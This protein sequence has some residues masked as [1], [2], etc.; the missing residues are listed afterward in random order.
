LGY[1]LRHLLRRNSRAGS[2]RN[3]QAHYDLGN[4]FYR[5]WLDP[6]MTYSSACF[7]DAPASDLAQAQQTKYRRMLELSGAK[8]GDS[9][10]E[11]G[12][13]WGGFA[14]YA[15]GQGMRVHGVTLSH[16]QLAYARRRI[17]QAG[18][19]G[20]A[21]IEL[22]DY[23]DLRGQYD[24]IVSIEMLEAVG[25]AY[26]AGYFRQLDALLKP[27]GRAAVQSIVIEEASFSHYRRGTDFIQQYIFP[28]GMLPSR[29]RIAAQAQAQA[30][31]VERIETFAADYAETLRRW[32]RRFEANLE[33]VHRLGFDTEFI[34]L[35]RFYLAYCEAGFDEGRIDLLQVGLKKGAAQ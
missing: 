20:L 4:D 9:I 32:S 25:E 17:A 11:I 1:R 35:W 15:A 19:A 16:Q 27:G 3:I 22:R 6:G 33:A 7:E 29:E 23:R 8:P 31:Q 24:A 26:W 13:G 30:L 10:L 34:R 28:G 21:S 12:C 18:L 2:A 14:E 5:L